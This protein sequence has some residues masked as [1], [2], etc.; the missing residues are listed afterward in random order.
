MRHAIRDNDHVAFGDLPRLAAGDARAT[1]FIR[2]GGFGIDRLAAGNEFRGA[3][4]HIDHV[5]VLGMNLGLAGLLATAGVDHVV[6]AVAIEQH[7]A[8]CECGI[9]FAAL[10]IGNLWRRSRG[11]CARLRGKCVRAGNRQ[12]LI[13]IRARGSADADAANN[14]TVDDDGNAADEGREVFQSG[15]DGAPFA[16]GIDELFEEAG[17]LLEHDSSAG[18]TN[19]DVRASGECSIEALEGHEVT[20]IVHHGNHAAWGLELSCF[21]LG[22]SDDLFRPAQRECLLGDGLRQGSLP[23]G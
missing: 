6:P 11:F 16:V 2:P 12:L 19:G 7:R 8:L 21:T 15:H 3:L 4:K 5:S 14:L 22:C 23:S 10:E 9:H 20:A 18:L 13:L 1:K 17:W